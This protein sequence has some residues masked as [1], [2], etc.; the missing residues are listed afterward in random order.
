MVSFST[1]WK[2][3]NKINISILMCPPI[4]YTCRTNGKTTATATV[5]V[6]REDEDVVVL[7]SFIWFPFDNTLF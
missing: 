5:V 2:I 3:L 4:P 7:L 1:V 6:E